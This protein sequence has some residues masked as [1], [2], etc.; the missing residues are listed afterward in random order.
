[1]NWEKLTAPEFERGVEECGRVCVIPIGVLERH[2]SHMPLGSDVFIGWQT[3]N[4]AAAAS[5]VMVFPQYYFGQI[6]EATHEAGTVSINLDLMIQLLDSVCAEIRRNGFTKIVLYSS[7][8]GN[9]FW[10]FFLARHLEFRHDYMLYYYF[11]MGDDKTAEVLKEVEARTGGWGEHAGGAE[12]AT[13]LYLFPEL[14]KL[15]DAMPEE[16]CI[17]LRKLSD[18]FRG[19]GVSTPIDWYAGHPTHVDGHFRSVTAAD[20]KKIM[21]AIVGEFAVL[22]DKIKA[23]DISLPLLEEFYDRSGL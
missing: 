13:A 23:D 5:E 19:S 7:H 8:G 6:P 21:D 3:A 22:L 11:C 17:P 12:T 16:K 15:A 2:G 14:V 4:L 18:H 9:T 1:M 20:G 10:K